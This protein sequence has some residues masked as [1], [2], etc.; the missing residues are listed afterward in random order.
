ML[1]MTA[2]GDGADGSSFVQEVVA[3]FSFLYKQN[4]NFVSFFGTLKTK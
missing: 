3:H 1:A 2:A 4:G